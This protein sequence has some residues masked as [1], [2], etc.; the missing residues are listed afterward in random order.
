LV[1]RKGIHYPPPSK[2]ADHGGRGSSITM[3]EGGI[4]M[5][6]AAHR[7]IV[8]AFVFLWLQL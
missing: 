6:L 3:T 5:V 4:A 2:T 1:E 8:S 7:A